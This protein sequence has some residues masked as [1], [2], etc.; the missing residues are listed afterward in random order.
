MNNR[1]LAISI[2]LTSITSPIIAEDFNKG[3]YGSVNDGTG[4][5]SDLKVL[6]ST[7]DI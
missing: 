6:G 2:C 4:K 5:F 3:V 1:F 7:S